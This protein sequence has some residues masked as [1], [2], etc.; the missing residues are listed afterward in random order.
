MPTQFAD[1]KL[2]F[3]K[4]KSILPCTVVN[5]KL[6]FRNIP[7]DEEAVIVAFK[8]ENGKPYLAMQ[9]VVT[10]SEVQNLVYKPTTAANLREKVKTLDGL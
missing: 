10:T 1:V 6:V 4:R 2:V 3:K 9:D 5:D 8:M 7:K